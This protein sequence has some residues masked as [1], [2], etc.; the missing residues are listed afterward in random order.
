MRKFVSAAKDISIL[1]LASL[2]Q[3]GRSTALESQTRP[4][5]AIAF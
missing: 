1:C 5:E 3:V 4:V 2:G